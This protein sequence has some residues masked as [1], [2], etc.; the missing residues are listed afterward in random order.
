MLY[1]HA[2]LVTVNP[3]REI[4]LDGCI[5]VHGN[6]IADIGK[7]DALRAKYPHEEVTD[8]TGRIVI[9]GLVCTHMHCAQTLLRGVYT[10]LLYSIAIY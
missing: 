3:S 1:T 6:L 5:L 9:P 2:T 8:L 4:I 7:T 10:V